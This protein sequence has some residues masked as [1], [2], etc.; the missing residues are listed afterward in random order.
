MN[1]SSRVILLI[2]IMTILS[3]ACSTTGA[4]QSNQ[5]ALDT[6]KEAGSDFSQIHPYDF[7]L[8]HHNNAG[9]QRICV[10]L[11]Q[12]GFQVSVQEGAIEG[13]W[14]C[15]ARLSFLP[16]IEKLSEIDEVFDDLIRDYGG[17]HDGWETI[18]ISVKR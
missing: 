10:E 18:V 3:T 17:E 8:Y 6:L 1:S 15:L 5:E 7:Y 13:E 4:D 9:S 16:S 2:V 14:F 11:N 12:D